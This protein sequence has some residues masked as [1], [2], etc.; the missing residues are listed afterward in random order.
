MLEKWADCDLVARNGEGVGIELG[1]GP[2]D[3]LPVAVAS[4]TPQQKKTRLAAGLLK[5]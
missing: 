1:G 2:E 3:D 5:T 4:N